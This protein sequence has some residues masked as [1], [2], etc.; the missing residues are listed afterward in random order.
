M[1]EKVKGFFKKYIE[2]LR[3]IPSILLT[4]FCVTIVVMN[5]LANKTIFQNEWLALDGGIVIT[6]LVVIIM[7]LVASVK[8]PK[9]AI[10]M[11]I[12]GTIISLICSLIFYLV[13][14]IPAG[15]EFKS[16]SQV[17][18][19][20]WF[21]IVSGAIAFI[22]SSSLN[23]I[24][25]YLLGSKFKKKPEGK[26][27][28]SVRTQVSTLISQIFDNFLFNLLAFAVFAPIF[29]NGFRWSILQCFT[30]SLV[31]GCIELLIEL[32]LFPIIYKIY[33]KWL[34]RNKKD[35]NIN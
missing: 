35:N 9:V 33:T 30:C 19:G 34:E 26:L 11:S 31:Y 13:S 10:K 32:L 1:G 17:L 15:E 20:T 12:F 4:L 14:I 25:N 2:D 3:S 22:C 8:G 29:W 7:D 6:W 27:A 5:V 28:F 23:A 21:I 18:G 24:L 16:F